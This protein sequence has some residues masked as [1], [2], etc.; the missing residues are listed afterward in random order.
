MLFS[1]HSSL[2]GEWKPHQ[3][4]L[5]SELVLLLS[6]VPVF[7]H[8]VAHRDSNVCELLYIATGDS[9]LAARLAALSD[10][11]SANGVSVIFAIDNF[12]AR[13]A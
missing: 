13:C 6:V 12:V 11:L 4:L 3:R 5:A 7:Y 8:Y 10:E 2:R 1:N 9:R